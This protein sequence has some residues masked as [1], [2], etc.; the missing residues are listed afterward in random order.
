L[1]D[2]PPGAYSSEI[3]ATLLAQRRRIL[4]VLIAEAG[5]VVVFTLLPLAGRAWAIG[6][7]IGLAAVV[8]SVVIVSR[9]GKGVARSATPMLDAVLVASWMLVLLVTGFAAIYFTMATHGD[10]VAGLHTRLDAIY[11][12]LTTLSTVGFGDIVATSQA[13]RAVVSVQIV[14]NLTFVAVGVRV[15]IGLGRRGLVSRNDH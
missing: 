14:F 3:R 9:R 2:E 4:R 13:A 5:L 6:V 15:L 11:F 12:T 10:Q 1:P 8:A 7:V